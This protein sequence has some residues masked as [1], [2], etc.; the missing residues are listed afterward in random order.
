MERPQQSAIIELEIVNLLNTRC[1]FSVLMNL[2]HLVRASNLNY[3]SYKV[4]LCFSKAKL[5]SIVMP[6]NVSLEVPSTAELLMDFSLK[7]DK[8][9]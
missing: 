3:L 7:G 8:D 1:L 6:K 9:K 4:H 5:L 2:A